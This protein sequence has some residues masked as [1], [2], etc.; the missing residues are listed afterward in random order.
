MA[1]RADP[2]W[3]LLSK[4][5]EAPLTPETAAGTDGQLLAGIHVLEVD[6]TSRTGSGRSQSGRAVWLTS[7]PRSLVVSGCWVVNDVR[8]LAHDHHE[9]PCRLLQHA[10]LVF[11]AAGC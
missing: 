1:G 5:H 6:H 7:Q 10:V 4:K 3:D 8:V 11:D 9:Q 2:V